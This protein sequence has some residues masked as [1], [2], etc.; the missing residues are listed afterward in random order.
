MTHSPCFKSVELL[1]FNAF[2]EAQQRDLVLWN[3]IELTSSVQL[4]LLNYCDLF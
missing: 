2:P 3:M 1:F 4:E